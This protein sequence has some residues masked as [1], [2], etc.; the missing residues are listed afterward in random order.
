[1]QLGVLECGVVALKCEQFFA[2]TL[3]DHA[4]VLNDRNAISIAYR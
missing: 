1:M 2:A 3:L 4:S